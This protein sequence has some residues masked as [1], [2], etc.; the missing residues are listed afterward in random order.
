MPLSW[1]FALVKPTNI[2]NGLQMPTPCRS[3]H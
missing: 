3:W 2:V 1:M